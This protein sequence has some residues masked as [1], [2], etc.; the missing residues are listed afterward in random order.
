MTVNYT[1]LLSLGQPVTGTESGTWGDDVNNA[2]TAYLDISIAGTLSFTGDGAVTLSK[3]QGTSTATNIG[4]STAQYYA[5]KIV[6]PLSATKVITAPSTSKGYVVINTDSTYGV[7]VKASGQTGVTVPANSRGLVAFDG[8]DYVFVA[9]TSP[10]SLTG[11]GT[12][13]ATALGVNVGSAGAFVVNGGALGTPSS[14]TLT[15][16]TGLPI[17]SGVSGL[18]S[19][20]ATFLA[21]PSSANLA[22]AVTG[23]TGSGALV[24]GTSPTI[25]SAS[26]VTPALGTPSSGTLTSCTGLPLTTGVTGTL[27]VANGGTGLTTTPTNGQIDIGNGSGFTRTTLTAGSGV[28]ISNGA[29]S[30]TISATGTGGTVTSVGGTGTVNGISL[31]G[32]VTSSGNLTLGGTLTGVNLASQ[33]TGTLP[34]ANGGTGLTATPSNGQIDI[35]NG[36]GFTR[37]TI[38]AGSNISITNGA[39]S[40]TISAV[41]GGSGSV[42]SV[43]T[44]TGLTGGPITTTGTISLANTA[45]TPTSYGSASQVATFTV[46]QQ[47]RLTAAGNTNIAI[48]NTAV[49]GLGTMSTQNAN[50][51]AVTG[52]AIN[53]VTIGGSSAAA[54]T[55]T[56]LSDSAGNVRS[57]PQNSQGTNYTLV[58]SDN[59]KHISI[60]SGTLTVPASVFSVGNAVTIFNNAGTSRT[61][62]Q[63]SG[64]TLRLAGSASTGNRTLAQ[65]GV[66]TILCVASNV[67]VISGGGLS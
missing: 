56:T 46:D 3:T 5:L 26:L 35:G 24:F 67:F 23:E 32:T 29:G 38:T 33:V 41:G 18:G 25:T 30:V 22:A 7:T 51:V 20:V 31:S 39:G 9:G 57:I 64:V 19:G 11:L 37:T 4:A 66:C 12:G 54:G 60:S 16:A 27:P 50:N 45:V 47:G 43:A 1:S 14:G 52:G 49:S 10:Q 40:I 28:S 2:V 17:S 63:G 36:S 48:A 44:G 13:V 65:Y 8:T 59:G 62:A 58:A 6:G 34:V 15:N 55:F 53:G 21:T 42:T 61:V